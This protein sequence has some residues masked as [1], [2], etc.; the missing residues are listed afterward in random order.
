M[1]AEDKHYYP[2]DYGVY[3]HTNSFAELGSMFASSRGPHEVF[4]ISLSSRVVVSGTRW[5]TLFSMIKATS[6]GN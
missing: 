2:I 1:D 3:I 6:S 4:I 5:T